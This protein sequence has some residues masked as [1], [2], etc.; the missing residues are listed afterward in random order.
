M[1]VGVDNQQIDSRTTLGAVL[2]NHN[3]GDKVTMTIIR[4][5]KQG[6]VQVTLGQAPG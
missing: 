3:A 6:T 2:S 5:G 1:I 4:A